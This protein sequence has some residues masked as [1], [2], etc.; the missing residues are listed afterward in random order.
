MEEEVKLYVAVVRVVVVEKHLQ[1][2]AVITSSPDHIYLLCT[3][4]NFMSAA[5]LVLFRW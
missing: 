2:G 4:V 1:A 5:N 3:E